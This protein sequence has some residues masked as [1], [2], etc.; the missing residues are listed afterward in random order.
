MLSY[1]ALGLR[2]KSHCLFPRVDEDKIE[3]E[4]SALRAKLLANLNA[5]APDARSLRPSDRH[6]IA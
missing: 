2:A 5:M 6:G 3:E 4:V 1:A